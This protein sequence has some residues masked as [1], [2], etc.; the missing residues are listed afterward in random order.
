MLEVQGKAVSVWTGSAVR[1]RIA[2]L[3]D[4]PYMHAYAGIEEVAER[5]RQQR[6][7][8]EKP[9]EP[10]SAPGTKEE[11]LDSESGAGQ[12]TE[13]LRPSSTGDCSPSQVLCLSAD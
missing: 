9:A 7:G 3:K 10:E 11:V 13:P 6:V 12:D 4:A 8:Q 1:R 5:G 2:L